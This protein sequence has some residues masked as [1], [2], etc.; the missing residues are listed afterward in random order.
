MPA[1]DIEMST[2]HETTAQELIPGAFE[3]RAVRPRQSGSMGGP[4]FGSANLA[5][6]PSSMD[7][8]TI[9]EREKEGGGGLS[10]RRRH[11]HADIHHRGNA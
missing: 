6:G 10:Q 1:P 8:A 9:A 11:D 2:N 3:R 4:G 5:A 7:A